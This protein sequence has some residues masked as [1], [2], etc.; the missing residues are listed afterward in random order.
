LLRQVLQVLTSRR[1]TTAPRTSNYW[2]CATK[3]RYNQ[4]SLVPTEPWRRIMSRFSWSRRLLA[5]VPLLLVLLLTP[6]VLSPPT[7]AA[8]KG[9]RTFTLVVIPDTQL[10]VQNKPELFY[11]QTRW[12]LE[13]QRSQRIPFVI[14]LG[15]VVE[16]PSRVSDWDRAAAAMYRLNG[17]VPYAVA[18]GNHDM[19]AWACTPETS[20]DPWAGIAQD[21]S[22]TMFNTYFPWSMFDRWHSFGGSYPTQAMDNS[23]FTF[24]AGKVRWLVITLKFDPT[25]DELAWANE[26]IRDHPHHQVIIDTHEYLR[27][28]LRTPVGERVWNVLGRRHPNIQFILSGHYTRV[29]VR[30]DQGDAGNIVYQMVADYMTYSIPLVNNN[31]YLR[32]MHFDTDAG[33]VAVQTFSPY[34]ETTGECPAY[35]TGPTNEFTLTGLKFPGPPGP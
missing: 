17:T 27:G 25:E 9:N 31:S 33:T 21:R 5:A 7:V 29:G 32:L 15:D 28:D 24:R 34:C 23:F 1:A 26:V 2:Y 8:A 3:S 35:L 14:H 22:T 18:V 16:W 30:V 20:C 13:N 4:L 19:D 11:A 6:A 12:I 10:A